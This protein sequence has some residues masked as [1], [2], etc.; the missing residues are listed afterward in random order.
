[1]TSGDGLWCSLR[2]ISWSLLR[3]APTLSFETPWMAASTPPP[4]RTCY[5]KCPARA[6]AKTH[7]RLM[8]ST[9][10]NVGIT[11]WPVAEL[12]LL[13]VI[14]HIRARSVS[15]VHCVPPQMA[16]QGWQPRGGATGTYGCMQACMCVSTGA[17]LP[18]G[19]TTGGSLGGH[20]GHGPHPQAGKGGNVYFGPTQNT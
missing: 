1:M 11:K 17:G 13:V 9:Q 7:F 5:E 10:L 3:N 20:S 18:H 6:R 15:S 12:T 2:A 4:A 8:I 14:C 19:G 16:P